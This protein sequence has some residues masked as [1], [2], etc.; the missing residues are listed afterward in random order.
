MIHCHS[1]S[2]RERERVDRHSTKLCP[3]QQGYSTHLDPHEVIK[4]AFLIGSV[5]HKDL[6]VKEK[7]MS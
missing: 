3:F 5:S 6:V 1:V 7:D 2:A 4:E